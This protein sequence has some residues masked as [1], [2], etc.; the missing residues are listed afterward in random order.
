MDAAAEE[1]WAAARGLAEGVIDAKMPHRRR[2]TIVWVC[3]VVAG[4]LLA[5]VVL[6]T[7]LPREDF[8]SG[9]D[10]GTAIT[11]ALAALAF[12]LAGVAVGVGG[13]IWAVRTRRYVARWRS[14]TAPLNPRERKW[15][16]TQVRSGTFVDNERERV[17][18]LAFASQSRRVTL[19]A[20][21]LYLSLTLNSV[22]TAILWFSPLLAGL[23]LA[24]AVLIP[25]VGILLAR[26]YRRAGIYLKRFSGHP[27]KPPSTGVRVEDVD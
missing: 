16:S 7:L 3:V 26:E 21:P 13:V 17:V 8:A 6:A 18:V 15:V 20:A 23:Q 27:P 12:G 1:R 2:S 19:A 9:E 11:R 24:V 5:G 10:D 22:A 25:T 4:I 14:V